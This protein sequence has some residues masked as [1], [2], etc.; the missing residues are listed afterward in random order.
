MDQVTFRPRKDQFALTFGGAEPVARIK[1][2]KVLS[3][4]TADCYSGQIT[5]AGELPSHAL[6]SRDLNPQ[7]GTF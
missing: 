6:T 1:P 5:A 2:G 4:W 7:T 3:L